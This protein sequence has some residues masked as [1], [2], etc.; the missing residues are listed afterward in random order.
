MS[1]IVVELRPLMV[2]KRAAL[3][4]LYNESGGTTPEAFC[5]SRLAR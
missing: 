1:L 2:R 3:L 4:G 5:L